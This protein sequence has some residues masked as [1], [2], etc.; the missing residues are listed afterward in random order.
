MKTVKQGIALIACLMLGAGVVMAQD[1][2]WKKDPF[3]GKLFPPNI[4]LKNQ[5][6]LNLTKDQFTS[7]KTAVVEV[8][9][10][11]AEHEWDLREAYQKVLAALDEDPIDE[12]QVLDYVNDALVA[13]NQVKKQQVSMLIR[14]KNLL[15]DDQ[16]LYLES[17]RRDQAK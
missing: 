2:G 11:I 9:A 7:I 3:K 5:A 8:Q 14:L 6:E 4:I 16:V 13:E 15:N 12:D 1:V 10:D 17:L